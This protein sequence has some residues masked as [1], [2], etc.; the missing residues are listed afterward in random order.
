MASLIA[1]NAIAYAGYGAVD[2]ALPSG[3]SVGNSL[4]AVVAVEG[5]GATVAMPS[6]WDEVAVSGTPVAVTTN[7]TLRAF[8]KSRQAGDP[9]TI[10]VSASSI[11]QAVT[12]FAFDA[13]G[14]V[15]AWAANSTGFSNQPPSISVTTTG[16]N[17]WL[18]YV[19]SIG[20][21]GRTMTPPSGMTQP[22][23]V[24]SG[25][26]SGSSFVSIGA[27]YQ[28][29]VATGTY[30]RQASWD[31]GSPTGAL[32]IAIAEDA[33]GGG[34][35][36]GDLGGS[37][38]ATGNAAATSA[39]AAAAA[40]STVQA[41]SAAATASVAAGIS[42]VLDTVLGSL[43]GSTA[44]AAATAGD[45]DAATD[46][47]GTVAIA[48]DAAQVTTQSS[49]I[50]AAAVEVRQADLDGGI[51]F[52]TQGDARVEIAAD[53]AQRLDAVLTSLSGTAAI[54]AAAAGDA[55]VASA[56]DAGSA[57]AA[58][59]TSRTDT[60]S[61]LSGAAVVIRQ[62]DASQTLD[63]VAGEI[64]TGTAISAS[65]GTVIDTVLAALGG[66]AAIG[67]AIE[68]DALTISTAD[69][70]SA[71][72]AS[73]SAATA[74]QTAIEAVAAIAGTTAALTAV[75][76]AVTAYQR[77]PGGPLLPAS[78][79]YRATLPNRTTRAALMARRYQAALPQRHYRSAA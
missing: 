2:V 8:R 69:A 77:P 6:G 10:S 5:G 63:A 58:G 32:M 45:A 26:S 47:A 61:E 56:N 31:G 38:S 28:G 40:A 7:I 75:D 1:A 52:S 73:A 72:A 60:V 65:L 36:A 53:M 15:T 48:A 66:S 71:I 55:A 39:I 62:A 57:I 30:A 20:T 14:A 54:G 59:A 68:S 17:Q 3:L 78:R 12:I 13:L 44:L 22:A 49:E 37:T 18:L 25:G 64:A 42:Q 11:S 50:S 19:A 67:S 35:I 23:A 76:T 70:G 4:F 79:T 74:T 33:G 29:P 24:A 21:Q 34:G 46:A 41:G 16:A 43:F 51:T 9:D 27:A